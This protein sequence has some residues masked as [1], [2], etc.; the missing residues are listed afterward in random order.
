VPDIARRDAPPPQGTPSVEGD[1]YAVLLLDNDQL[2]RF[3]KTSQSK[4]LGARLPE[5]IDVWPESRRVRMMAAAAGVVLLV[6]AAGWFAVART[7]A[8]APVGGAAPRAVVRDGPPLPTGASFS[9]QVTSF[10]RDAEATAMAARLTQAGLPAYSWRIDGTRRDVLVGPFVSIDEADAAQRAVRRRGFPRARLHVDDRLRVTGTRGVATAPRSYP[11]VVLA[12][13]P[14]RL[15]LVFELAG[16]PMQVSGQRVD[17]TTFEVSASAIGSPVAAQEWN[18]PGDIRL[19]RHVSITPDPR[20]GRG[21]DAR[22]TVPE[23][24]SVSVRLEG[25][26]VYVDITRA[27]LDF[28]DR[29]ASSFRGAVAA[30]PASRAGARPVRVDEGRA[31][32]ASDGVVVGPRALPRASSPADLARFR[33]G[34]APVFARFEQIQPFLRSAV[35]SPSPEVLTAIAGTFAELDRSFRAVDVPSGGQAVHGFM[36]SALD[37]ASGAVALSFSGDRLSQV[38]EANAQYQ[39]ARAELR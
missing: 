21:L 5:A 19:L 38:R 27:Q 9:V 17:A 22:V 15:A 12:A 30:I 29:G 24:A 35:T 11:V 26:R 16:E 10:A 28:E 34:M 23:S 13:A 6:A 8:A 20:G 37:L 2:A 33:D 1:R 7:G 32:A 14:G 36:A 18:A 25:S 39:A 4:M 3:L 31:Q